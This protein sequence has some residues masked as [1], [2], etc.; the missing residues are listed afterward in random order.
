MILEWPSS[1]S[2]I[3]RNQ[4]ARKW[5]AFEQARRAPFFR[6]RLAG[7]DPKRLDDPEVWTKIPLLTKD[8]LRQIAPDR[9]HDE[10]CIAPR[11]K[12][13]E[14]WR[15]PGARYSIRVRRSTWRTASC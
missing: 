6:D 12:V 10:F 14:Y 13:V 2:E 9:F 11:A 7:I 8:A 4:S 3:D 5:H 1:R 15:S